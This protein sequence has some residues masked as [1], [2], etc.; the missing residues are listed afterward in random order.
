[1][2]DLA[3]VLIDPDVVEHHPII[4]KAVLSGSEP[5]SMSNHVFGLANL[6]KTF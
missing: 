5:P 1:M 3:A 4:D 6:E 2:L